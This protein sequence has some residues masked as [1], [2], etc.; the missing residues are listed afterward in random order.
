VMG[1]RLRKKI[2][3]PNATIVLSAG[4]VRVRELEFKP[5]ICVRRS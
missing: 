4:V 3:G 1:A 2:Y 5:H